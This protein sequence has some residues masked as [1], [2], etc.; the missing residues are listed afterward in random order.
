MLIALAW[1][2]CALPCSIRAQNQS[3]A[4][5]PPGVTAVWDLAR[6]FCQTTST[7]ECL[8][9]NG[10][11]RWQPAADDASQVPTADWGYYKV[12]APWPGIQDYMQNDYQTLYPNPLW[13]NIN[14]REV[15]SAWYE[16]TI[17]IPKNWAGRRIVLDVEYLNSYAE[18]CVDGRKLGVIRFP[19]G[20]V[21]LTDALPPG[22]RIYSTCGWWQ[23]R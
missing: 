12:P 2:M 6:A 19:A 7:R 14:F 17:T 21:D 15:H 20:E 10:L 8:C 23:C 9:I 18:V 4:I 16:R 11:W 5:L 1:V 22:T 3:E 13:E